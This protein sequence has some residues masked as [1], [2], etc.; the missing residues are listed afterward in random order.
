M[1]PEPAMDGPHPDGATRAGR[2]ESGDVVRQVAV[3]L[4]AVAAIGV[5][6]V[7]SGALGGTPI[8]EAAGGALAADATLVAPAGPAFAIWSLI[9]AGLLAL[10]VLQLLPARRSDPR[11]R[12]TG[13]L[14]LASLVL[15]AAWILCVQAGWVAATVPVIAA[16]VAVLAVA[17]A[18][19]LRTPPA[20][21]LEAALV[22]GTV[23]LYLGWVC[24]ATVADVAAALADAGV[25]ST[26]PVAT[27]WAVTILAVATLVGA[28]LAVLG[29]G[30]LAPAAALA[31]GLAWIAVA[32]ATGEPASGVTAAA[33]GVAAAVTVAV[34][35]EARRRAF[36]AGPRVAPG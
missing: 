35:L 11:Q 19:L 15:N 5:S 30:R 24:I 34:A 8:A 25:D 20:S 23:G 6:F 12:S 14:V 13:W 21:R 7:G 36:R 3:A 28:G 2:P 33:A 32:R 27:A 16:L 29:R 26:G 17:W 31:W 1:L 4:G 22:D 18:R 9:Y 10:A